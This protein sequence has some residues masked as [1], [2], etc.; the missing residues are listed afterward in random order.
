M[1]IKIKKFYSIGKAVSFVAV[2][3]ALVYFLFINPLGYRLEQKYLNLSYQGIV[4]DKFI[5]KANHSYRVVIL[6]G[7]NRVTI[8]GGSIE[9]FERIELG[10]SLYK[11]KN[12]L[13]GYIIK[14]ENR[15]EIDYQN[16]IP[17]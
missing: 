6:N 10:D 17:E 1:K 9:L 2:L 11:T 14:D 12:Q 8:P 16:S 5:D 4:T 3:L 13:V 15:I 7:S